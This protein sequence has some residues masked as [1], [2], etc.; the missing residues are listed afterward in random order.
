MSVQSNAL[1]SI[2]PVTNTLA[3]AGTTTYNL[4]AGDS[5][6]IITVA[7]PSGGTAAVI[8]AFNLPPVASSAGLR[9]KFIVNSVAGATTN[10]NITIS[11]AAATAVL[12]S[13]IS[14]AVTGVSGTGAGTTLTINP[15]TGGATQAQV[16]D[17]WDCFCD[18]ALWYIVGNVR[19]NNSCTL[20]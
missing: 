1:A 8:T 12:R 2:S 13:V 14:G 7:A 20:A 9:Y 10:A 17:T 5:G 3:V 16:G 11:T 4:A 15:I 18:G 6:K 19:L